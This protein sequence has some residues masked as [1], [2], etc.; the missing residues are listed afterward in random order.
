MCSIPGPARRARG[1]KCETL[2]NS[3]PRMTGDRLKVW[4]IAQFQAQ[5]Q[6]SRHTPWP[7][8]GT[9]FG[10]TWEPDDPSA[11]PQ[12]ERKRSK[13]KMVVIFYCLHEWFCSSNNTLCIPNDPYNGVLFHQ[14]W[15]KRKY[16]T[17]FFSH[18][19]HTR[20]Y[21]NFYWTWINF[22]PDTGCCRCQSGCF[23]SLDKPFHC[24][25]V[26][27]FCLQPIWPI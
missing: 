21:N 15:R 18:C 1:R 19:L 13:R 12:T 4:N 7:H 17:V 22:G 14:G 20:N 2:L 25:L 26:Y 3:R 5:K 16:I 8:T 9:D 24:S 11:R 23:Q 10:T 27:L 6:A